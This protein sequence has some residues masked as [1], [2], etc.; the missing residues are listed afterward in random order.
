MTDRTV[1]FVDN[2]SNRY[3]YGITN[4]RLLRGHHLQSSS[5]AVTAKFVIVWQVNWKLQAK[6]ID[7]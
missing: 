2:Y 1:Y 7:N 5:Q 4:E 6:K 3:R